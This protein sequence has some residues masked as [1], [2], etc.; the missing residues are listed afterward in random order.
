MQSI[1]EKSYCGSLFWCFCYYYI[2]TVDE[3]PALLPKRCYKSYC[4]KYEVQRRRHS[5]LC[6]FTTWLKTFHQ[7]A[8]RW[9]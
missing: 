2:V 8:L 5:Y 4:C 9:I 6:L 1:L 7:Y 3:I